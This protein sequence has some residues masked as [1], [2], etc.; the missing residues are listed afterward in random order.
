M[1]KEERKA[2]AAVRKAKRNAPVV[3]KTAIEPEKATV[4]VQPELNK[5]A[6]IAPAAVKTVTTTP[7]VEP[8]ANR[9]GVLPNVTPV[10]G[11][12][13]TVSTGAPK[14]VVH[15]SAFSDMLAPMREAAI[16]DKTD[17]AKMQK[18]YAL[19]DVFSALGKMGGSAIGGAIGGNMF[20]IAATAEPYKESRG[21]LEAFEKA[22]QAN[23]R[24]R[25]LDEQEFNLK[26]SKQQRDEEMA[27]KA[28]QDQA[29]REY[30]ARESALQRDW[31]IKFFNYKT[32]IE[33]A[34]ADKNWERKAQ[35]EVA[36]AKDKQ[37]FDL[38]LEQLKTQGDLAVQELRNAGSKKYT[39]IEFNHYGYI[40]NI[41][42]EHYESIKN[43]L[44][45]KKI[46]NEY[47]D[48]EN[49]ESVIRDNP[50]IV[51]DYLN[52]FGL[53][54]LLIKPEHKYK[55]IEVTR[56]ADGNV[57]IPLHISRKSEDEINREREINS[58]IAQF[59]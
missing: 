25:R 9:G 46:G 56:D 2:K 52:K 13:E 7:S 3:T 37:A 27:F 53:G 59:E 44:I 31:D 42:N 12:A 50:F 18:Y 47:V 6:E 16:K 5:P 30:K 43:G 35:L 24:L 57:N 54:H 39:P 21:Y 19:N 55:N 15:T 14:S 1:N 38:A 45:G 48:E 29:N 10:V 8:K 23:D 34:I 20:D 58:Y 32:Q 51:E 41:P 28:M 40:A 4:N 49:V 22:K 11:K 17:A 36:M 26:L 33:Q